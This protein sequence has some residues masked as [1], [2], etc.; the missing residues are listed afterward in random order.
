M[1]ELSPFLTGILG[2]LL[3]TS[4]V[5]FATVLTLL[6]LA[7]G[8]TGV[9]FGFITGGL[10]LLLSGALLTVQLPESA[11][12][13]FNAQAVAKLDIEKTFTPLMIRHTDPK[14]LDQVNRALGRTGA[15]PVPF[16]VLGGAFLLSEIQKAFQ[17]GLVLMIPF[18]VIDL[19]VANVI[20]LL[21]YAQL[22]PATVS[23]PLKLLLFFAVDGWTLVTQRLLMSYGG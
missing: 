6:R 14:V 7:L 4:F 9:T 15:G 1:S 11:I 22:A 12:P 16:S 17:I 8:L 10:A 20:T 18:L 2:L 13:I 23:I 5:R 19:L 3:V 21:G